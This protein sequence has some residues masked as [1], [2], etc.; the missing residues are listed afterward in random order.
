MLQALAP[1]A[2]AIASR[3]FGS[4]YEYSQQPE[5]EWTTINQATRQGRL[6]NPY[7]YKEAAKC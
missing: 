4:I 6:F 2:S 3:F 1:T 7:P 5:D